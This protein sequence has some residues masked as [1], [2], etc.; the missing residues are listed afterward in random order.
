MRKFVPAGLGWWRD[1]PDFRD[2]GLHAAPVRELLDMLSEPPEAEGPPTQVDLRE[3]F[4]PPGDQQELHAST[5]FACCGLLQ[6]FE[7]RC[8]G[9][10][11]EPAPL[12]LYQTTRRLL[13]GRGDC[14]SD[15]RTALKALVR[16]G[17]P[18]ERYWPYD[19]QKLD[20]EPDPFLYGFAERCR[21]IRYV[22]LDAQAFD[23]QEV[24]QRVKAFLAAGFPV[25]CGLS[26]P[27]SLSADGDIP[28]RPTF[29]SLYGGQAV[30]AVGYDDGHIQATRG[31][32]LIRSSW[33]CQWG[34]EG[35]GWLPYSFVI[36][37][38]AVNFWTLLRPQWLASDELVR[39]HLPA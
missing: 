39:P 1:L 8:Y 23:G 38:Q 3:F 25:A 26:V 37:R 12:F 15:L 24:L 30:V 9:D 2:Y 4:L 7:S 17:V 36:E 29:D 13:C 21:A 11:V 5:A 16:F 22:S 28:W 18:P 27:S 20:S 31:A 32:L 6:Y 35:Y 34:D 10:A 19:P 14:G 33:G